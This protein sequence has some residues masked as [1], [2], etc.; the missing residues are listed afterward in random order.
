MVNTKNE[1]H[2]VAQN[3][4]ND[5]GVNSLRE[6]PKVRIKNSFG[7]YDR[8]D[9]T[10]KELF[11]KVVRACRD[12]MRAKMSMDAESVLFERLC[13]VYDALNKK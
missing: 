7:F 5:E 3:L 4:H 9:S 2:A 8:H 13:V 12:Y 1:S 10:E 6:C 11:M